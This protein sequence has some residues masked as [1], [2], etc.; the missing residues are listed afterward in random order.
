MGV[1]TFSQTIDDYFVSIWNKIRLE[2]ADNILDATP[3]WA[4]L[5]EKGC[6]KT[7]VGGSKIERTI[8]YGVETS[9]AIVKGDVLNQ[10][11]PALD[12]A[13]YWPQRYLSGHIQRSRIDDQ[14]NSGPAA[15]RNM[16]E[17]RIKAAKDS[18][19]AKFETQIL[20][21]HETTEAGKEMQNLNDILPMLMA[22]GGDPEAEMVAGKYGG[23]D[24]CS[25]IVAGANGVLK[26]DTS[27]TNS[28]WG[29]A[30]YKMNL[31]IAVN[32]LSDMKKM[33][34]AV[35][36]NQEF[37]D[38]IVCDL[39][40]FELYE[41]F[42]LDA[43]QII[44]DESTKMA[45]LG[46]EVLRFKGKPMIWTPNAY[47]DDSDMQMLFLNSKHIEIVYDPNLWFEM[48]EWKT[49]PLQLERIA[50]IVCCVNVISDQLRRHGRL[51]ED[52]V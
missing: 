26:P 29:G 12:T 32:L 44:K 35:G 34:N 49:I 7:Q 9:L 6:M 31:P 42:A 45:D 33:Y 41:D 1:P 8:G 48:G 30:V 43:T 24:R 38:M 11:E 23:I 36:N 14:Q 10:G 21:A 17:R 37:P 4:L 20:G 50:H 5:K 16:V 46:F 39:N 51:Y 52:V 3:V 19:V 47:S 27:G 13:A 18:L 40:S 25:A 28:W 2:I 15:L 22:T